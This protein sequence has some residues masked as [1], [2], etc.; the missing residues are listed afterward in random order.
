MSQDTVVALQALSTFAAVGGS[1]EFDVNISV[2]TEASITVTSFH[3]H[4]DNY[5]LQQSQ[6]VAETDREMIC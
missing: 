2:E 1:H 3:I 4:Q 6:Q 5:L